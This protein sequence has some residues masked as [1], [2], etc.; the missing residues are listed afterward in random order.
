MNKRQKERWAEAGP[1]TG[2]APPV[3]KNTT[4][5]YHYNEKK[6]FW[7]PFFNFLLIVTTVYLLVL[8]IFYGD[9]FRELTNWLMISLSWLGIILLAGSAVAGLVVLG[10]ARFTR[11]QQYNRQI[12]GSYAIREYYLDSRPVRLWQ[13]IR[14]KRPRIGVYKPD[15]DPG[16]GVVVD[17]RGLTPLTVPDAQ[18]QLAYAGHIE[19]RRRIQA[20]VSPNDDLGRALS[21]ASFGIPNANTGK[22]L[23]NHWGPKEKLTPRIIGD[24]P[25]ETKAL[26]AQPRLLPAR[27]AFVEHSRPVDWIAGPAPDGGAVTWN[28]ESYPHTRVHG[29]SQGAG[30][31][32]LLRLLALSARLHGTHVIVVDNRYGKDWRQYGNKIELISNPDPQHFA[33]LIQYLHREWK[34]RDQVLGKAATGRIGDLE[35]NQFQ[36]I[37]A[38]ISETGILFDSL[39]ANGLMKD[40]YSP[41]SDLMRAGGAAGIHFAFEDQTVD[42]KRWPRAAKANAGAV[43]TGYLPEGQGQSGGYARAHRL[44]LLQFHFNG[45][46][47]KPYLA[48]NVERNLLPQLRPIEQRLLSTSAADTATPA[49]AGQQWRDVTHVEQDA[50]GDVIDIAPPEAEPLDETTLKQQLT[51]QYFGEHPEYVFG[52]VANGA[53]SEL[54]RLFARQLAGDP[55]HYRTYKSEA[56]KAFHGWRESVSV[57]EGRG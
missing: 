6:G 26:P 43:F 18:A 48:E 24:E 27:T 41:F 52:P 37:L 40:T 45:T 57:P 39:A 13:A 51:D 22:F 14:G 44:D 5:H 29:M 28:P 25:S 42:P 55:A 10:I 2:S 9:K 49:G 46:I 23:S 33:S 36:R 35:S 17:E 1:G 32:N 53:I 38:V 54:A 16:V 19:A 20:A 31:T 47:F 15:N 4:T 34:R 30:K 11:Q 56:H 3:Q 50:H 7:Y 8:A 21:D 12:R